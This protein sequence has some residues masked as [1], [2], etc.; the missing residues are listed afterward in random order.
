MTLIVIAA[1]LRDT[2]EVRN[3]NCGT[4][5]RRSVRQGHGT[6][7]NELSSVEFMP[8]NGAEHRESLR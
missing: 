8:R 7:H 6:R 5:D 3:Y 1:R 4:L 2:R